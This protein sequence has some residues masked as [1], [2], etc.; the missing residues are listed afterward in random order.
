MSG[1]DRR[2]VVFQ[3][4]AVNNHQHHYAI[5]KAPDGLFYVWEDNYPSAGASPSDPLH[6]K[7]RQL[8]CLRRRFDCH[9][10]ERTSSR[11]GVAPAEAQRLF[12]AHFLLSKRAINGGISAPGQ[13]RSVYESYPSDDRSRLPPG[14]SANCVCD[15]DTG[16]FQE[17]RLQHPAEAEKFYR[18]LAAQ[19]MQV[20]VGM[21]AR[22]QAR[23]FER[24]SRVCI[25]N[26]GSEM[27][28]RSGRRKGG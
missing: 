20:R 25:F 14:L 6:R 19:G 2:E 8:C 5:Q 9:R 1:P 21:E 23:W 16:E 3:A 10:V 15:T 26:C 7:L 17:R 12:T 22:G 13:W 28:R 11:A 18:D 27:Q 24:C 4:T